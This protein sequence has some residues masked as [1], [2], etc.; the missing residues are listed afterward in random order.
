M[1]GKLLK[2]FKGPGEL[3]K[4][5]KN[6][7]SCCRKNKSKGYK[8]GSMRVSHDIIAEGQVEDTSSSGWGGSN[9]G[10]AMC[11]NSGFILEVDPRGHSDGWDG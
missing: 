8:N 2:V 4:K 3:F 11:S 6:H 5:K 1:S 7:F 9:Q 10:R